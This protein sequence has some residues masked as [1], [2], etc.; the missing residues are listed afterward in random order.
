MWLYEEQE[1]RGA[2]ELWKIEKYVLVPRV[3]P[4]GCKIAWLEVVV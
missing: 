2:E 1:R 3:Q 4:M